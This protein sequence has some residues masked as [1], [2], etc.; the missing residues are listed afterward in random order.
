VGAQTALEVLET[1][2]EH[3]AKDRSGFLL[4]RKVYEHGSGAVVWGPPAGAFPAVVN[5]R[6]RLLAVVG[7]QT[8]E[9]QS[10]NRTVSLEVEGFCCG[11][12]CNPFVEAQSAKSETEVEVGGE[13]HGVTLYTAVLPFSEECRSRVLARCRFSDGNETSVFGVTVASNLRWSEENEGGGDF[14]PVPPVLTG[15]VQSALQGVAGPEKPELTEGGELRAVGV[16]L[17]EGYWAECDGECPFAAGEEYLLVPR[18]GNVWR[19]D[20]AVRV[21]A[22]DGATVLVDRDGRVREA[23]VDGGGLFV[24]AGGGAGF[25]VCPGE[26][27]SALFCSWR[28]AH[29]LFDSERE[30]LEASL[31]MRDGGFWSFAAWRP[32]L[33]VCATDRKGEEA[34]CGKVPWK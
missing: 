31:V 8:D 23:W 7:V 33:E 13:V 18:T 2:V 27:V 20:E 14:S 1:W 26:E 3:A 22:L 11:A 6:K 4:G 17:A 28:R 15:I 25:W 19:F 5:G 32:D 24:R 21:E 10:D 16:I 34:V 30:D 12:K 29:L 9:A